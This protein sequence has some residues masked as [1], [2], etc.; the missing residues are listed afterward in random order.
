MAGSQMWTLSST[1]DFRPSLHLQ[2]FLTFGRRQTTGT[3][4][5]YKTLAKWA[6]Y[7]SKKQGEIYAKQTIPGRVADR[8]FDG[9]SS[10]NPVCRWKSGR[11]PTRGQLGRSKIRRRVG[12]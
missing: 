4:F 9:D 10:V 1:T 12:R 6:L 5:E 11:W 2:T 7:T 3:P 8:C